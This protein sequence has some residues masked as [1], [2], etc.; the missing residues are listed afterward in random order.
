MIDWDRVLELRNEVLGEDFAEIFELFREEVEEVLHRMA[1]RP[2]FSSFETDLH[3]LKG[4]AA[5]M[6]FFEFG[7]LCFAAERACVEGRAMS[8]DVDAV[9]ACYNASLL[10]VRERHEELG[11]AA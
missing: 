11:I 10:V 1:N 3:F 7:E 5:N 6:G 2:D 4:S 8:I 9:I